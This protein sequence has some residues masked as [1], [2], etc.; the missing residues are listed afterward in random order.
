MLVSHPGSNNLTI[1]DKVTSSMFGKR[2]GEAYNRRPDMKA[3]T[4]GKAVDLQDKKFEETVSQ[5]TVE[6]LERS[7][8]D[9]L[10]DEGYVFFHP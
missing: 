5:V 6:T 4:M 9:L 7:I 2:F 10:A 1:F 8:P 3:I